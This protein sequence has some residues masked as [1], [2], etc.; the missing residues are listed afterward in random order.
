[1]PRHLIS[2]LIV[3]TALAAPAAA[4]QAPA[5]DNQTCLGCHTDA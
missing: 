3:A 2:A 1:M 4:Q 5:I